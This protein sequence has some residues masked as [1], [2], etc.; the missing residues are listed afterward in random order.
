MMVR[1]KKLSRWRNNW[2]HGG[3]E[4]VSL[5]FRELREQLEF[6]AVFGKVLDAT[7]SSKISASA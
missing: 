2:A 5:T 7:V 6:L 4:E 1:L 3:D